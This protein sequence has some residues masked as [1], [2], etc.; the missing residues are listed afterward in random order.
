M[1]DSL[2]NRAKN[3]L[4]SGSRGSEASLLEA[5]EARELIQK[6][7]LYL[8]ALLTFGGLIHIIRRNEPHISIWLSLGFCALALALAWRVPTSSRHLISTLHAL[9]AIMVIHICLQVVHGVSALLLW[10]LPFYLIWIM[11]LPTLLVAVVG[12][13]TSLVTTVLAENHP[14]VPANYML[15]LAAA[16]VVHFGKEQT[17]RHLELASSDPLTGALNRRYLSTQL[18]SMRAE[19]VRSERI[20]SLVLM[21]VDGL[22]SIN[23]SF[24][25]QVGD[26]VLETFANLVRERIRGSDAL[27]RIGGDEFALILGDAK[28]SSALKVANDLRQLLREHTAERLPEFSISFGVCCVDDSSSSDDWLGRADEALYAA[29]NSGGDAAR[30]TT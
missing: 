14:V 4:L 9:M 17:L 5:P 28:A 29:K 30:M 27:F 16:L 21:D 19:Y 6:S 10:T 23:D 15:A 26:R 7:V 25:H 18:A 3:L 8:S 2:K 13:A 20:S 24:G 1:R 22:K 12:L 11:L